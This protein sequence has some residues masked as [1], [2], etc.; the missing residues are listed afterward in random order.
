MSNINLYFDWK[1]TNKKS[2]TFLLNYFTLNNNKY[3]IKKKYETR[4][5]LLC[6]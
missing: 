5:T 6:N 3:Q 1:S 2:K 4:N